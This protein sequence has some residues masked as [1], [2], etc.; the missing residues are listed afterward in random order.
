[1]VRYDLGKIKSGGHFN[2]VGSLDAPPEVLLKGLATIKANHL[3]QE[4]RVPEILELMLQRYPKMR[5]PGPDGSA[6]FVH[7]GVQNDGLF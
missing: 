2:R 7:Q 5:H 6:G 4:S 3:M 1:M